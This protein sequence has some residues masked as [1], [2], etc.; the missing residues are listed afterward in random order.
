M[1]FPLYSQEV[2][3]SLKKKAKNA[4]IFSNHNSFYSVKQNFLTN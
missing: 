4:K 2:E 3:Q 1:A